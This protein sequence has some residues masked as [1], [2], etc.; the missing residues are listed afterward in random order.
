M[1]DMKVFRDAVTVWAAGGPGDPARELAERFGVRTAV[2]LE[3]LSDAA[4]IEALAVRRGRDLAAE[5][6]ASCRWAVR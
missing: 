1:A 3:G 6:S 4:A 2:L 5:G